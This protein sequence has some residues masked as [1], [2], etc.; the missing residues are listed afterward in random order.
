MSVR[1]CDI[2]ARSYLQRRTKVEVIVLVLAEFIVADVWL[3][4]LEV[5][6]DLV[7]AYQTEARTQLTENHINYN[8]E[9]FDARCTVSLRSK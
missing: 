6:V 3:E 1:S 4:S 7:V 2:E 5:S 8:E 9:E